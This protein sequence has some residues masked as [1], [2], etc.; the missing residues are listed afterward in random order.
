MREQEVIA[1]RQRQR[2]GDEV[3]ARIVRRCHQMPQQR[4]VE[5]LA[6]HR[7]YLKRV[8]VARVEPIHPRLNETL[9]GS[10]DRIAAPFLRVAKKLLQEQRIAARPFDAG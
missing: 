7:G 6:D 9:N 5:T 3:R 2:I 8:P 4:Q 1:F 10:R